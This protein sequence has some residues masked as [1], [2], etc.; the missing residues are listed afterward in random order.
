MYGIWVKGLPS[1]HGGGNASSCPLL[2]RAACFARA[3]V[4]SLPITP[5]WA[6]TL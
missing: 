2:W 6:L 4:D 3:S 1:S 5:M